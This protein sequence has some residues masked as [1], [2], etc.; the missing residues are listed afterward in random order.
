[1]AKF[2]RSRPLSEI[3]FQ[4]KPCLRTW[5]GV[6]DRVE[7]TGEGHHPFAYFAAC[8]VC[9]IEREQ[10]GWERGLL[11]AWANATGPRTPEGLAATAKNLEGHPT[12]E[13]ALRTRFNAMKHGL[14][15]KTATY[16]PA[17]PDGYAFCKA[18][19]VDRIW[20]S[21]QPACVKQAQTFMLHHA[22]FESRNPKH[23]SGI[24]ADL[25][26]AIFSVLQQILQT[27]IA[28]GVKLVSPQY[29]TDKEGRLIV[30]EYIDETGERRIIYDVEAHPLFRPLGEL[31]SRANL[32]LADMGMTVKAV[33]QDDNEFGELNPD[34][35]ESLD[36]Y[37]RRQVHALEKLADLVARSK[38]ATDRD[39][40]LLEH[41]QENPG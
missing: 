5:K 23:L 28:D 29:Y 17:R 16:F 4:C 33:E 35:R 14:T 19:E 36:D 9:G 26:A 31:L 20:C 10:V 27:I 41:N 6:P 3:T 40:V 38:N 25:Q 18:C 13:E 32:S 15:A 30:A 24:Y 1:M 21:G 12:P 8:E 39:P 37:Q 2:D 34:G 22:A 7:D 11:K